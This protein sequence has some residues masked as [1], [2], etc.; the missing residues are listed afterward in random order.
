[1]VGLGIRQQQKEVI[2]SV[3]EKTSWS[4]WD[5]SNPAMWNIHHHGET[6]MRDSVMEW[7]DIDYPSLR[8]SLLQC[9]EE[10]EAPVRFPLEGDNGSDGNTIPYGTL[11]VVVGVTGHNDDDLSLW[12]PKLGNALFYSRDFGSYEVEHLFKIIC[13]RGYGG[14]S[15]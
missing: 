14:V 7:E 4:A 15:K 11:A 6:V 13:L 9:Q 12:L 1:M 8:G 3:S 5:D 10:F 2:M